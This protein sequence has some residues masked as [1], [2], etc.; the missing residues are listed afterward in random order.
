MSDYRKRFAKTKYKVHPALKTAGWGGELTPKHILVCE[1]YIQNGGDKTEALRHV[2]YS[3][4]FCKGAGHEQIFNKP[5][6]AEYILTRQAKVAKKYEITTDRILQEFAKIAFTDLSKY[7]RP[8]E[9]GT[10]VWDFRDATEDDL[11]ALEGFSYD[12]YVEGKGPEEQMS[13][14]K[15]KISRYDKIAALNALARASGLFDQNITVNVSVVERLQRGR[16]RLRAGEPQ[17][18]IE[19]SPGANRSPKTITARRGE[20][21]PAHFVAK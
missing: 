15:F 16:D 3:E 20:G 2:G 6:V 18:V 8:Q 21:D 19:P 5:K 4:K 9:D 7:M 12:F 1:R 14:K 13:L 17:D 10:L 11:Q